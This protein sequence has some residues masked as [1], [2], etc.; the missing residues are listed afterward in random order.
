MSRETYFAVRD[1]VE[2]IELIA[3]E[4]KSAAKSLGGRMMF[5]HVPGNDIGSEVC[6]TEFRA[7]EGAVCDVDINLKRLAKAIQKHRESL[8]DEEEAMKEDGDQ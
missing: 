7:L 2:S 8:Y 1:L 4:V 6:D 5:A 3:D